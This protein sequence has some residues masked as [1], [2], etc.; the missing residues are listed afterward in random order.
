MPPFG[1]VYVTPER[2]RAD[3]N[4][5]SLYGDGECSPGGAGI[6]NWWIDLIARCPLSTR[7]RSGRW[8]P[9]RRLVFADVEVATGLTQGYAPVG[10]PIGLPIA[11]KISS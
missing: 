5:N 8:R 7:W 3:A 2:R 6:L 10:Q 4:R 1:V 9:V 11:W